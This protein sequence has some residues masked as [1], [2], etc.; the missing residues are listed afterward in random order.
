MWLLGILEV[1]LVASNEGQTPVGG[2]V[3]D[4]GT[5]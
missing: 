1:A 4:I 2:V 3:R 5:I